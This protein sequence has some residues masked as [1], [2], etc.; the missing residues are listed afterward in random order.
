MASRQAELAAGTG[1]AEGGSG[2]KAPGDSEAE[3]RLSWVEQLRQV[4]RGGGLRA[5]GAFVRAACA[6]C[7]CR[8]ACCAACGFDSHASLLPACL[9]LFSPCRAA[10]APRQELAASA[11]RDAQQAQRESA[12]MLAELQRFRDSEEGSRWREERARCGAHG[13][14]ASQN[15][16]VVTWTQSALHTGRLAPEL[17]LASGP[18]VSVRCR[19]LHNAAINEEELPISLPDLLSCVPG[20]FPNTALSRPV[21]PRPTLSPGPH[22]RLPVGEIREGLLRALGEHD[23]VVVSGETGSGKT[24]QASDF[25]WGAFVY[26]QVESV[27]CAQETCEVMLQGCGQARRGSAQLPASPTS[28]ATGLADSPAVL[29]PASALL[30]RR[31]A[32]YR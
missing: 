10:P 21:P 1:T 13:C 14:T 15:W 23:V 7:C 22:C 8:R 20:F 4:G 9:L 26:D 5:D 31:P 6:C 17:M 29:L 25:A 24:T 3:A 30:L 18:A 19:P 11:G 28:H 16:V 12:A 2:S 27:G 32:R